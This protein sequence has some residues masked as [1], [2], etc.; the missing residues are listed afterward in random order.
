[1]PEKA[2]RSARLELIEQLSRLL[3]KSL[4][5]RFTRPSEHSIKSVRSVIMNS[6]MQPR[7]CLGRDLRS[8]ITRVWLPARF[9]QIHVSHGSCVN[10]NLFEHR[11]QL[12]STVAWD[13]FPK[14]PQGDIGPARC[15]SQLMSRFDDFGIVR[16]QTSQ[17]TVQ[18]LQRFLQG[19]FWEPSKTAFRHRRL[20]FCFQRSW[21]FEGEFLSG[22]SRPFYEAPGQGTPPIVQF[23]KI[24]RV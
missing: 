16:P 15:D 21:T 14:K 8:R 11:L 12:M 5:P 9:Q 22:P 10:A 20:G 23:G 6:R 2:A 24:G 18:F 19:S 17:Q 7:G 1:M 4:S 13:P 3:S